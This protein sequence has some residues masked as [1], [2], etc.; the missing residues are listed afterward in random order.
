MKSFLFFGLFFVPCIITLNIRRIVSF[1]VRAIKLRIS[2]KENDTKTPYNKGEKKENPLNPFG[3]K[4]GKPKGPAGGQPKFNIYWIY[5]I[6]LAIFL[7][8]QFFPNDTVKT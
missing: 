8:L 3:G 5:G 4:K 1:A 7:I 2:M 6:I